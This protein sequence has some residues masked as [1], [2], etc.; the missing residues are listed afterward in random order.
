MPCMQLTK[1]S[2]LGVGNCVGYSNHKHFV[3]YLM[4]LFTLCL[5]FIYA[6]IQC[7]Y[8]VAGTAAIDGRLIEPHCV[9]CAIP[10][11][12]LFSLGDSNSRTPRSQEPRLRCKGARCEWLGRVGLLQRLSA[13]HLGRLSFTLSIISSE[14]SLL[15]ASG[16]FLYWCIGDGGPT[17]L[18]L[19]QCVYLFL[20][21]CAALFSRTNRSSGWQWPRTSVWTAA[22][23][24]TLSATTTGTLSVHSSEYTTAAARLLRKFLCV[25]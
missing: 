16:L 9:S 19:A 17:I 15:R 3:L 4:A 13:H 8:C 14:L 12:L 10:R 5:L 22:A 11:L 20:I 21:H 18:R 24:R 25:Y 6:S 2:L 1:L 7:E 23:I